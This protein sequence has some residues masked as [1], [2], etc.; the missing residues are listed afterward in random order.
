M[1]AWFAGL[2]FVAWIWYFIDLHR[3]RFSHEGRVCFGDYAT[4]DAADEE[5]FEKL[6]LVQEG[7]FFSNMLVI[8]WFFICIFLFGLLSSLIASV[9]SKIDASGDPSI[10]RRKSEGGSSGGGDI[11]NDSINS[12][13]DDPGNEAFKLRMSLKGALDNN[14]DDSGLAPYNVA[15]YEDED[16]LSPG[17]RIGTGNIN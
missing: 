4:V 10:E 15:V 3:V 11:V 9:M 1:I 5:E 7:T 17:F 8:Q 2:T 6:Y 16:S 14:N 12:L 13:I